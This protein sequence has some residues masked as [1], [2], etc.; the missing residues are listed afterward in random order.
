MTFLAVVV[1]IVIMAIFWRLFASL[2]VIA[3]ALG[4]L[5]IGGLFL[6]DKWDGYQREKETARA[7]VDAAA[8]AA[9]HPAPV[10]PPVILIDSSDSTPPGKLVV[11]VAYA[12]DGHVFWTKR[13]NEDDGAPFTP[14]TCAAYSHSVSAQ[15]HVGMRLNNG[16]NEGPH[17]RTVCAI[18][19]PKSP[20][21]MFDNYPNAK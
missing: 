17:W 11:F 13:N 20:E 19:D 16:W 7:A 6:Y 3:V 4:L 15:A 10:V 9:A 1:G 18:V 2:A 8:Y 14:A 21:A 12:T 5:L